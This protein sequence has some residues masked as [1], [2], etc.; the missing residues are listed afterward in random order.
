MKKH[1]R[2]LFGLTAL[3]LLAAACKTK[4]VPLSEKIAKT[5]T[6]GTVKE[7]GTTVFTKGGTNNVKPGYSG[8]KLALSNVNGTQT[9]TLTEVD[10]NTFTGTW[11]LSSDEKRLTLRNL[12]PQPTGTNGVIEYT[13]NGDVTDTQLNLTRTAASLKTGGTINDYQLTNP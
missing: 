11:E 7:N 2:V 9:A 10:G 5:W 8:F 13:I 4:V 6:A 12:N 1:V 3:V